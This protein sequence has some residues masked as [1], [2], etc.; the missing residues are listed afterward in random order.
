MDVPKRIERDD[1]VAEIFQVG[2]AGVNL[3]RLDV[4][5]RRGSKVACSGMPV[6]VLA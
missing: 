6:P 2:W 1:G 5:V 3:G 4:A